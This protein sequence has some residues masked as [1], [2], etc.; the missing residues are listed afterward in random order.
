MASP[1]HRA[2]L[3]IVVPV[4][5][6]RSQPRARVKQNVFSS[7]RKPSSQSNTMSAGRHSN[8]TLAPPRISNGLATSSQQSGAPSSSQPSREAP[9]QPSNGLRPQASNGID[10]HQPSGMAAPKL[11]GGSNYPLKEVAA[12]QNRLLG[13]EEALQYSPFSSI[14]PFN[15]GKFS[16]LCSDCPEL[17][18]KTL[19]R[20]QVP[21]FHVRRHYSLLLLNTALHDKLWS[22]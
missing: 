9:T 5:D 16:A 4:S 10:G 8:G 7:P 19:Y 21:I 18:I 2:G 6:N 11:K 17:T 15:S 12:M 22:T 13:V 20:S 14:I 3:A 1:N